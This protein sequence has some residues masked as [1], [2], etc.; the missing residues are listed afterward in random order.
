MTLGKVLF[1]LMVYIVL[2]GLGVIIGYFVT[3]ILSDI[4]ARHRVRKITKRA[5]KQFDKLKK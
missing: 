2:V 1:V 5:V 4:V 3:R